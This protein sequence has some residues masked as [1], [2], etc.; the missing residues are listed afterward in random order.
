VTRDGASYKGLALEIIATAQRAGAAIL[1]IYRA[2]PKAR[3]KADRSPVTEADLAAEDIILASLA[4]LMPGTP[5]V[6]EEQAT[7]GNIPVCGDVFF[8]VDPLDG[9]KEFLKFNGEFT[10]NIALI[11]AT[12]P[13]FGLVYAPDK[14]D[15]Y[16]TLA[17]GK[18]FR[19]CLPPAHD[20]APD[21]GLDFTPLTGEPHSQRPF[22]ALVSR[23]HVRPQT[24]EFLE[25]LGNPPRL[26]MGSSLKFGLLARGEADVYPRFGPTSEWDTAAGQAIVE[27][28]GGAVL[29]ED[30]QPLRYGKVQEGYTNPSFIARRRAGE[31]L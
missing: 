30:G 20:A 10:V 22:T 6:A 18:S 21:E 2:D 28:A 5:V 3:F 14:A 9:T 27:A 15:C 7:A 12:L 4:K 19:C 17:P 16:V 29:T 24:V 1:D 23:S 11:E 13:V 8:L 31:L 26:V 25:K